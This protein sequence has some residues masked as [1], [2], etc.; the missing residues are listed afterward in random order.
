[1]NIHTVDYLNGSSFVMIQIHLCWIN[2][3][4]TAKKQRHKNQDVS[5]E[6]L[7][8]IAWCL[9]INLRLQ[10]LHILLLRRRWCKKQ[11]TCWYAQI[12]E[13]QSITNIIPIMVREDLEVMKP[14]KLIVLLGA[15][16]RGISDWPLVEHISCR[17][18]GVG[19]GLTFRM[20]V[21]T[22]RIFFCFV[23]ASHET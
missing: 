17:E 8:P 18:P 3:P 14:T 20:L 9:W 2:L 22:E 5:M 12:T 10:Q 19:S 23:C 13:A 6:S 11:Q 1:M 4:L 15:C 21:T 7:W 16:K